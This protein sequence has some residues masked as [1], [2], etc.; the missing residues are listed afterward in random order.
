LTEATAQTNQAPLVVRRRYNAPRERVFAAWADRAQ[1][2]RWYT[3]EEDSAVV[4]AAFDFRGGGRSRVEFGP[5]GEP[6]YVEVAEY[7]AIEPPARLAFTTVPTRAEEQIA[8]TSCVID[9]FDLG[10]S[11]ELV[12]TERSFGE[13]VRADRADG[14]GRTLDHLERVL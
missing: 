1:L 14:W 3:P 8:A 2:E 11:T 4:V 12:M 13:A 10:E 6:P 7:L 5:V 9:F